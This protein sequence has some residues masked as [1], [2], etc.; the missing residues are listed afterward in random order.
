LDL[1]VTSL[2]PQLDLGVP[3]QRACVLR[4]PHG[5]RG[6][7]ERVD[8]DLLPADPL[9]VPHYQA[10]GG[11]RGRVAEGPERGDRVLVLDEKRV[12]VLRY[13][14]LLLQGPGKDGGCLHTGSVALTSD[15]RR[16]SDRPA[17]IAP[18]R[19]LRMVAVA[20][21]AVAV[22]P[23]AAQE[24]STSCWVA[25]VIATYRST[26][27]WVPVPNDSGRTSTTR[28]NS[29]PLASSGVSRCTRGWSGR[30]RSCSAVAI[31]ADSPS[32]CCSSQ[33]SSSSDSW[34]SEPW[35]TGSPVLRTEVGTFA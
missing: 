18:H 28:S 2:G 4:R 25:L 16:T 35:V 8:L 32:V 22:T 3:V 23:A 34:S 31:T 29:S 17:S 20:R 1:D 9:C 13:R 26:V 19:S 24:R 27:A 11:E 15:S 21:C 12:D 6:V 14:D 7:G 33:L 30:S 10:V 5:D